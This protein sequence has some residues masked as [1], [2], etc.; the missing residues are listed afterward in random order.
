MELTRLH[1]RLGE[2]SHQLQ[3]LSIKGEVVEADV[4]HLQTASIVQTNG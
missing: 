1:S 4:S 2:D 3:S